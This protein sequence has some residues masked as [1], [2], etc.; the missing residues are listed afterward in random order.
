[1]THEGW[2][3]IKQRNRPKPKNI[4]A[5]KKFTFLSLRNWDWK[6]VKVETVK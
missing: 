5:E 6:N 1:M 2:H 3:A 4:V